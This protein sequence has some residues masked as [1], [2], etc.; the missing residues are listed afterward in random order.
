MVSIR[1]CPSLSACVRRVRLVTPGP[2]GE[3]LLT[4]YTFVHTPSHDRSRR[5][6]ATADL[7]RN[8][9]APGPGVR[10]RRERRDGE[11]CRRGEAQGGASAPPAV[12][13]SRA[14]PF[15]GWGGARAPPERA[16]AVQASHPAPAGSPRSGARRRRGRASRG[17]R[18]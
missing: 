11:P 3:R 8:P 1:R 9:R 13:C 4:E 15:G 2:G 10:G 7:S 12:E 14:T 18:G 17:G 6:F 16:S 5:T